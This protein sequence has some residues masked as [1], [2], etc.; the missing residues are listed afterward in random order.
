MIAL[1]KKAICKLI[2]VSLICTACALPRSAAFLDE[3]FATLLPSGTQ[4]LK[5]HFSST[6]TLSNVNTSLDF[7]RNLEKTK[8]IFAF[9]SPLFTGEL[10]SLLKTYPGIIPIIIADAA[11]PVQSFSQKG[12]S[13]IFDSKQA[14]QQAV[15]YFY[16]QSYNTLEPGI[17]AVITDLA[18]IDTLKAEMLDKLSMVSSSTITI[19]FYSAEDTAI[20]NT[21]EQL[22]QKNI[23]YAVICVGDS[24]L[25]SL[26][27]A[28]VS[29]PELL[30]IIQGEPPQ[31]NN[32]LNTRFT[33]MY[34]DLAKTLGTVKFSK[35]IDR[36]IHIEGVWK[37][38][39]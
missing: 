18:S 39:K 20:G 14:I 9:F 34:W 27:D 21:L 17:L 30:A 28:L 15:L 5:K 16:K 7:Y 25:V 4:A 36:W 35:T 8:P 6:I 24:R 12:Y 1:V 38:G 23:V 26:A 33:Y 19:E 37:I 13:I 22:K 29:K 11:T 10:P 32:K 3:N 2:F 31:T